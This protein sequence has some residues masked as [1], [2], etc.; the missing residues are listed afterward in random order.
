MGW[1]HTLR[2]PLLR[3]AAV[4]VA[5][6]VAL[7]LAA[8]WLGWEFIS[9]N[10]LFSGIIAANVFLMGFLLSGVLGRLQGKR[11]IAW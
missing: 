2:N 5:V 11:K 9:L 4:S 1:A 6:V 8:H 10:P 7:K 3:N